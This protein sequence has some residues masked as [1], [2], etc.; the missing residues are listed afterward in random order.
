MN[1][2]SILFL[3]AVLVLIGID[4]HGTVAAAVLVGVEAKT[5]DVLGILLLRLAVVILLT[6]A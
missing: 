4:S 3:K 2:G 6:R 5:V 1:Q